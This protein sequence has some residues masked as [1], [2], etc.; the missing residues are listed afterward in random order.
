MGKGLHEGITGHSRLPGQTLS[1]MEDLESG[2]ISPE[3]FAT[4]RK[5]IVRDGDMLRFLKSAFASRRSR[6]RNGTADERT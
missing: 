3:R 5:E 6:R 2:Q 4:L 1:L